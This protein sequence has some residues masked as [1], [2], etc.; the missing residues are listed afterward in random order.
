MAKR[1][2]FYAISRGNCPPM[3]SQ[4]WA[5]VHPYVD[6]CPGA[7]Y[8]GFTTFEEAKS[9]L[10]NDGHTTFHFHQHPADGPKSRSSLDP[11]SGQPAYYCVTRGREIGIQQTYG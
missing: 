6:K 1:K 7:R 3:V 4:C 10:Y 11:D 9:Y 5:S 2:H 8:K